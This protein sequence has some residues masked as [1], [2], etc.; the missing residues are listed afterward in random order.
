MARRRAR[1][2]Q[3]AAWI[4]GGIAA[5]VIG[6][7][8]LWLFVKA[9][10]V[11]WAHGGVD[12]QAQAWAL[13]L[14]FIGPLAVFLLIFTVD[15]N[16]RAHGPDGRFVAQFAVVLGAAACALFELYWWNPRL[17]AQIAANLDGWIGGSL[18]HALTFVFILWPVSIA[19][20]ILSIAAAVGIGV[21][22]FAGSARRNLRRR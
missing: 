8:L 22:A 18:Q 11:G 4:L 14:E 21:R 12:A 19:A 10:A 20:V 5:G 9:H 13:A 1:Q 6:L 16:G 17:T 3:R 15:E 7:W 2:E